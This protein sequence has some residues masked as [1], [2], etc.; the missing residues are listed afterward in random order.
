MPPINAIHAIRPTARLFCWKGSWPGVVRATHLPY[1][2][3]E[4]VL[5]SA[6]LHL[7]TCLTLALGNGPLLSYIR[8]QYGSKCFCQYWIKKLPPHDQDIWFIM[9]FCQIVQHN[10][11]GTLTYNANKDT[12]RRSP[13]AAIQWLE[14]NETTLVIRGYPSEYRLNISKINKS[15][16]PSNTS[17]I[18]MSVAT[19]VEVVPIFWRL[20][21]AVTP[22]CK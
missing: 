14:C 4:W 18:H 5:T 17:P 9:G 21:T 12:N 22:T 7:W 8:L 6:H 11:F 2:P 1:R 3:P 10:G 20:K 19:L 15:W 13:T 16:I